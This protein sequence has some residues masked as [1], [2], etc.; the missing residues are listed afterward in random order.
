MGRLF[1]VQEY[2]QG[3]TYANLLRNVSSK[4][5][6]SEAEVIQWLRELLPVLTYLHQHLVHRDICLDNIMLPNGRSQPMLIDFGLVKQTVTQNWA[7]KPT[8]P[9]VQTSLL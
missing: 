8:V 3:E 7:L 2:I 5:S 4:A 1:I 9:V 6:Y